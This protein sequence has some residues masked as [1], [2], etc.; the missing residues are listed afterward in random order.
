MNPNQ[1]EPPDG[2]SSF[3]NPVPEQDESKRPI[4]IIAV[5][6]A[7][8]LGFTLFVAAPYAKDQAQAFMSSKSAPPDGKSHLAGGGAAFSYTATPSLET[9]GGNAD[10]GGI[11]WE[12]ANDC[13]CSYVELKRIS[14]PKL[15][16]KTAIARFVLEKDRENSSNSGF[17]LKGK[18][19]VE[20]G[21][22]G[23]VWDYFYNKEDK[24]T[25]NFWI[26]GPNYSY[27][28]SCVAD[29]EGRDQFRKLCRE[30]T[31]SLKLTNR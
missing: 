18:P 1:W 21:Y 25:R 26:P 17:Y 22:H 28:L 13:G 9:A 3:Q 12:I 31:R 2:P 14:N 30:A 27:R 19:H 6:I 5:M 7:L 8:A 4:A 23:F 16:S 20:H 10:G 11:F 24:W 29:R 15:G